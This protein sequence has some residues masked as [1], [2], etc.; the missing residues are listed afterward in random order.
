MKLSNKLTTITT[1]AIA[2]C[3][4]FSSCQK[5]ERPVLKELILDP[6]PP[7]YNELKA[8]WS[9][10]NNL[11]DAGESKFVATANAVTYVPGVTGQAAKIG[12]GGYSSM[13]VAAF[14][15]AAQR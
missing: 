7:A 11:T 14:C 4:A 15:T 1:T 5:M 12:T 3:L 2:L 9:F 6:D 13:G 10:E 8:F